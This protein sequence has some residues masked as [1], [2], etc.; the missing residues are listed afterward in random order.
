MGSAYI[1]WLLSR[2]SE[3]TVQQ[4][5]YCTVHLCYMYSMYCTALHLCYT[6]FTAHYVYYMYCPAICIACIALLFTCTHFVPLCT[7]L[8]FT[9][10][11]CII[12]LSTCSICTLLLITCVRTSCSFG[13]QGR[14]APFSIL[15][16]F[17]HTAEDPEEAPVLNIKCDLQLPGAISLKEKLVSYLFI[18]AFFSLFYFGLIFCDFIRIA[19]HP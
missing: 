8:L 2:I 13:H 4:C 12:L 9:C 3:D 15:L 19:C 5:M 18:S 7:V 6:Y 16:Y 1:C 17:M 14:L 10:A 11:T